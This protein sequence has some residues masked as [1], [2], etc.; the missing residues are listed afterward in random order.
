MGNLVLKA[1]HCGSTALTAAN[2]EELN[3]NKQTL[4]T[5]IETKK[6]DQINGPNKVYVLYENSKKESEESILNIFLIKL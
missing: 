1:R 4:R 3:P 5:N 2:T 6:Q